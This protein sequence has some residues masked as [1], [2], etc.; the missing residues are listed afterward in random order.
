M[1]KSRKLLLFD[2]D[3]VI[4]DSFEPVAKVVIAIALQYNL[5]V[6][7]EDDVRDLFKVNFYESVKQLGLSDESINS[8]MNDKLWDSVIHTTKAVSDMEKLIP[9]LASQHTLVIVSSA[10]NDWVLSLLNRYSLTEYFKAILGKG[11]GLSKVEK[12]KEAMK[13][14]D[15]DKENT[16]YI[17]DTTGDIE[18]GRIVGVKTV[19]VTWGYHS[20]ETMQ[21]TK[22]D[23]LVH[24]VEEL[25]KIFI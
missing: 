23:Y 16:Y 9:Q 21:H 2:F 8:F 19:G 14:Y 25:Q 5:P 15:F 20:A 11:A 3:G 10:D 17:G 6:K 12:I 22:P 13:D 7:K 4:A 24:T 1:N 18:E